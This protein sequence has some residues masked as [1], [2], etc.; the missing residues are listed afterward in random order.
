MYY[1]ASGKA[2]CAD[3]IPYYE[4]GVFYLYYLKDYRDPDY[5][6]GISWYL[7][8][9]RDFVNYEEHGEVIPHGTI[10][11]QDLKVFTGSCSKFNGEYYIFYTGDNYH[12]FGTDDPAEK[13]MLAKSHDLIHWNKVD[14][15]LLQAPDSVDMHDFRDPFVYYDGEKQKYCM[16]LAGRVKNEEPKDSKGV[17]LLFCSEDLKN[18]E[19]AEEPFY[20]P[21]AF[22]T[23]ECPDLF[24][25]GDWWYLIFSE[26]SDK[27]VTTYRMAKSI[28]GPWITPKV[29]TFDGSPYYAAKTV[30][31]GEHR[32]LLG[33]NRLL[34]G[35]KDD[36]VSQ[37]G[38]TIVPHEL[39]QAEDG[40]LYVKCPE[41]IRD[42]YTVPVEQEDGYVLRDVKQLENGWQIGSNGCRGMKM[43]GKMPENCKIEMDF[44]TTDEVGEFGILLRADI[45]GNTYY[46]VKFEPKHNRLAYDKRPRKSV[47]DYTMISHE[48]YCPLLPGQKNHLVIIAEGSVLEVYVNDRVAMSARMFDH[49][50]GDFGLYTMNTSVL[51][52]NIKVTVK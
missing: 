29:D 20:A 7:I 12:K 27:V 45:A 16:L 41:S 43:L 44:T 30:S 39:V 24:K 52:E 10:E 42:I 8:T 26:Y 2:V 4:D 37:W 25:M 36:G 51:F 15:F 17:T 6:D 47:Y 35:E 9:T 18:W 48:R 23:H 34:D 13:I 32:Y 40:S 49:K 28:N 5:G 46:N 14:D 11:D 50:E 31:D 21:S 38:G 19:L 22:F 33:W 1:R 3:V